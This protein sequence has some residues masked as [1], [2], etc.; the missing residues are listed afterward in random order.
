MVGVRLLFFFPFFGRITNEFGGIPFGKK[1]LVFSR[2][3]PFLQKQQLGA[4][5]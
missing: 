2:F 1:H 3:K 5:S 4:F